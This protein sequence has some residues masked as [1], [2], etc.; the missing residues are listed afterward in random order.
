ETFLVLWLIKSKNE[1]KPVW[2]AASGER[3]LLIE[4]LINIKAMIIAIILTITCFIKI[5]LT[6]SV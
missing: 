2:I 3:L 6:A 4:N 1:V 5:E